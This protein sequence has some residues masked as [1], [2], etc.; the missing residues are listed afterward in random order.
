MILWPNF[1]SSNLIWILGIMIYF[2]FIIS[3]L[4]IP[5]FLLYSIVKGL[6]KK[7]EKELKINKKQLNI[8]TIISLV[9]ALGILSFFIWLIAEM[10]INR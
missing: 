9:I 1:D 8:N 4:L 2:A 10:I 6:N 3:L 7:D 5:F